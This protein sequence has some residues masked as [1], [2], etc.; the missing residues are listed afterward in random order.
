MHGSHDALSLG[1]RVV[2]FGFEGPPRRRVGGNKCAVTLRSHLARELGQLEERGLLRSRAVRHV[3]IGL[4]DVASN[5]YLGYARRIVS[6][7]TIATVAGAGASRLIHGTC[8]EHTA[9]EADLAAWVAAEGSL[10]FPTGYMANVGAISALAG[11][12]D[13]IVS[14]QLN[15]ASLI[16]GCRLSRARTEVVPHLDLR[17]FADALRIAVPGR[18][19][20]ITESYFSMDGD[21][22]DLAALRSIAD[23]ADAGLLVDEAHALGVFGPQG[24]GLCREQGI[25]PDVLV[26]TLGKAVGVQ[27]AFVAGSGIL[28][29]FLWNRARPFVFTTAPSPTITAIARE[30]VARVRVDDDARSRLTELCAQL[31]VELRDMNLGRRR[32]GPVFPII[33]RTP[34]LALCAA[35]VLRDAGFL[36]Q[37]IRP[38]TVPDGTSRLRIALHADLRPEQV[39]RLALALRACAS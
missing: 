2:I 32:R 25:V 20:V 38:P 5:D 31:Q 18:R 1:L 17:A 27:G 9:L 26:G 4:V 6:R 33:R 14:D 11:P 8:P 34:G 3:D 30:N 36:T 19:W 24:A 21:S 35:A 22:P 13:L 39:S 10:L 15:H 23:E 16:D 28:L 29:D 7:E 12:G 37:A